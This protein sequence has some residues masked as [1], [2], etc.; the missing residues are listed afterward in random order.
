[1]R[2]QSLPR[3]LKKAIEISECSSRIRYYQDAMKKIK[4]DPKSFHEANVEVRIVGVKT[5]WIEL[6]PAEVELILHRKLTVE[7]NKINQLL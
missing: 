5:I 6:T 4:K 2:K 1:M 7:K 3:K